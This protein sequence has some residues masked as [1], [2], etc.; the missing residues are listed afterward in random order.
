MPRNNAIR[1]FIDLDGVMVNWIKDACKV[2]GVDMSDP[3]V[4]QLLKSDSHALETMLKCDFWEH[5]EVLKQVDNP[6][7]WEELEILPWAQ[8]LWN[9]AQ[10]FGDTCILTAPSPYHSCSSGKAK[11]I[12][13]TFNT[14]NWLIGKEKQFCA[15]RDSI[16]IDD[17]AKKIDKFKEWGGH[18]YLWP[19]ALQLED[20]DVSLEDT[21]KHLEWKLMEMTDDLYNRY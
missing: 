16:L 6:Q 20:G 11:W 18:G 2:V 13:N 5:P 4:R 19:N 17:F 3:T 15:N 10:T 7:W 9:M 8:R 1:I 21:F 12:Q 14:K